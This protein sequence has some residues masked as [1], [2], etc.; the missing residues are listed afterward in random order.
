MRLLP[1]GI[2]T[3]LPCF[4]DDNEDLDLESYAKHVKFTAKAGT[5]PVLSGSMGEAVHLS[6]AERIQLIKTARTA[7]DEIKL[8]ET[9]IVAGVGA[10]STR[11]SI[12]LAKEAAE[13]GADFG[14]VIPPGYYAGALLSSPGALK[15]FFIDIAAA[16][17]IPI[18]L[19][20]FPALTN[21]IDLDSDLIVD[22]VKEAPNIC[23]VKLTC[24]NVGKLTRIMAILNS[25]EFQS[26]YPRKYPEIPFRA[27]DGFIDFLL[28]SIPVG[29][30]G[31]ISG[32]PNIAPKICVKLWDVC[33]DLHDPSKYQEAQKL[34][35]IISLADGI[36]LK[37]GISGMKKLLNQHFGYGDKPRRPLLPMSDEKANE[38]F[39][40]PFLKAL[41]EA[42]A[43]L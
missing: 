7:L 39:A 36:A 31:A 5:I 33:Q 17:P 2:Y 10:S 40:S 3:P 42:E 35:N 15:Q 16:S 13:A 1:A 26:A 25:A 11:E 32:L 34:Q 29:S 8:T 14:M 30:S 27:I 6:R 9:P 38:F 37:I 43:A 24:A 20:N 18:M 23:G 4:F 12:E 41:L 19:Y 21:G 22:V 28:P